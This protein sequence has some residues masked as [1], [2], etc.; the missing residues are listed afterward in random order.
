M[1]ENLQ[2]EAVSRG[3]KAER[4][5]F[6]GT[7]PMPE[8]LAR[9]RL[10]DLFLDTFPYNAGTTASDSLWAGLPVLTRSG[11][12]FASRMAGSIL[13]A[14]NTPELVTHTIAEYED[15]A[16][17]LATNKPKLDTIR[18]KIVA[19]RMST[20]LFNS[21]QTTKNIERAYRLMYERY[22]DG[23]PPATINIA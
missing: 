12:S 9:Y 17:E 23:M 5:I 8:Y 18:E 2:V 15:L 4:L 7:L 6:S 14:I 11:K 10:A 3:V 22:L 19:N 16:V 21:P 13:K 20:P 1:V